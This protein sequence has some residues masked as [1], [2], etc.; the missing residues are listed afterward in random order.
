MAVFDDVAS[1]AVR[2]ALNGLA[3]RQRVSANNLAN[4][5]T[6]GFTAGRLDFEN[7]LRDAVANGSEVESSVEFAETRSNLAPRQDGNNVNIDEETLSSMD[8]GLRFKLMLRAKDDQYGLI[9]TVLKGG[10]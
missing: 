5:E 1:A 3:M 9:S 4:I 7:Q 8:T 6:P 10:R 2:T